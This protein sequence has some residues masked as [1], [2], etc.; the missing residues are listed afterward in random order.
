MYLYI[1]IVE[2]NHHTLDN[3]K[4][5]LLIHVH[6]I[7]WNCIMCWMRCGVWPWTLKLQPPVSMQN[8]VSFTAFRI[9]S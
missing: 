8:Y 9:H 5:T 7:Y 2:G 3:N 1:T 6:C 4:K